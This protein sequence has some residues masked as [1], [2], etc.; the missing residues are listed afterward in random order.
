[1]PDPVTATVVG[2]SSLVGGYLQNKAASKAAG[3]QTEAAQYAI[4]EQQRQ[5]DAMQELL[6]PYVSAGATS[7]GQQQTLLGLSGTEAQQSAINSIANSPQLQAMMQ[8]GENAMAQNAAATGG[9]RGGNF[10]GAL[11]QYRP[12][13]LNQAINQQYQNLAGLT[14]LGQASAAGVGNAGMQTAA[15]IGQQYNQIGAAQAG[16]ALAQGKILG[17]LF[18]TPMS[19]LGMQYGSGS[20]NV[21]FGGLF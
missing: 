20:K 16:Q 21:G 8:Q 3:A 4:A 12:A 6:K 11:A 19:I 5:F 15:Q 7:L 9:L 1:M 10:Q 18:N 13:M 14:S 17:N 2:G